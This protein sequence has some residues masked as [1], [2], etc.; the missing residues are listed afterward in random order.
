MPAG[1]YLL[2]PFTRTRNS[3]K[4]H[5]NQLFIIHPHSL[6]ELSLYIRKP[7]NSVHHRLTVTFSQNV[8]AAPVNRGCSTK[9]TKALRWKLGLHKRTSHSPSTGAFTFWIKPINANLEYRGSIFVVTCFNFPWG[10]HCKDWNKHLTFIRGWYCWCKKSCWIIA[11]PKF[12]KHHQYKF[13]LKG[14]M[15]SLLSAWKNTSKTLWEL[16]IIYLQN[17][18]LR[19][20]VRHP[21]SRQTPYV[22][23]EL[24]HLYW[25][26]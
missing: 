7:T 5:K 23:D 24:I 16:V 17:L 11:S 21:T 6:K 10:S 9:P 26:E 13:S 19:F 8:P 3:K 12:S 25:W 4:K 1:Y 15:A 18:G 22:G 14:I 20:H 2:H